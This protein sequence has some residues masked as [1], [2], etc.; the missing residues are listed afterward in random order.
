MKPNTIINRYIFFQFI[1]PFVVNLVFFTFIFLMTRILEITNYIVNYG[2]GF[3]KVLLLLAFY[4]PYFMSFVI[5]M[6]V[7]MAVLLTFLRLSS[8]NE[9]LALKSSGVSLYHLLPPVAVFCV[10][11]CLITGFITIFG[12]PWGYV[13]ARKMVYNM[14]SDNLNIGLKER[15]FNNSFEGITLYVAHMDLKNN[16]LEDVFIEDQRQAGMTVTYIAPRGMIQSA[17]GRLAAY[18]QLYD[19]TIN[20]VNLEEK[21]TNDVNFDTYQLTLSVKSGKE[22]TTLKK[23]LDEKS[24]GLKDLVSAIDSATEKNSRYY[25]Y[26]IELMNKFSIPFACLTL[27]LLAVPLG[28]QSKARRQS[29]GLGLGLVFFLFYYLLLSLGWVFGK[30]GYYPP[31]I[32][33]WVPN[34]VI[35]TLA[36]VFIMITVKE[37]PINLF[38]TFVQWIK[39]CF[40]HRPSN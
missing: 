5:P 14:A 16:Q 35:G 7:M 17:P 13:S 26:R 25:K 15:A 12:V 36:A 37:G 2:I 19:G 40:R 29:Y 6:S 39:G 33:I 11:G 1:P 27:G 3:G 22:K 21:T 10:A 23:S 4:M 30:T 34:I 20:Y 32:G 8:D 24:M 31:E 9:I 38:S 18:L 28:I